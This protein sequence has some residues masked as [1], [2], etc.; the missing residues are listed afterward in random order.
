MTTRH[1][2]AAFLLIA[3]GLTSASAAI[4]SVEGGAVTVLAQQGLPYQIQYTNA[5]AGSGV[6]QTQTANVAAGASSG[7][8]QYTIASNSVAVST[9]CQ[10]DGSYQNDSLLSYVS[11]FGS[12]EFTVDADSSYTIWGQ[13]ALSGA[14][15]VSLLVSF[16]D[17]TTSTSLFS[18]S[19][20]SEYTPNELLVVGQLTGESNNLT[21]SLTG[22]VV[23]GHQYRLVLSYMIVNPLGTDAGAS[24]L[25]DV[26]V[27]I[28]PEPTSGLLLALGLLG[29]AR[30]R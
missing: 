12:L 7:A 5:P 3:C 10:R 30:R 16:T 4:T 24:S 29:F 17:V 20:Y 23:A 27:A 9:S 19:Q 26:N 2:T 25:G 13:H 8:V 22:P 1:W 11:I 28:S 21:G 14:Q 18:N 15:R 6:P